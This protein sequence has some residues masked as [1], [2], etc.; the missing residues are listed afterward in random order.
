MGKLING[1][2]LQRA[3]VVQHVVRRALG[4]LLQFGGADLQLFPNRFE[5]VTF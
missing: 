3:V 4:A 1:P 2:Y 5:K